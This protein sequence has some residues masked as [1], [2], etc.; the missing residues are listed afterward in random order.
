[1][2]SCAAVIL[3]YPVIAFASIIYGLIKL[4]KPGISRESRK[5]VLVRHILT[6]VGFIFA[7]A[8]PVYFLLTYLMDWPQGSFVFITAIFFAT[9][10]IYMT[11]FRI[12]EPYFVSVIK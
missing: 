3:L 4:N 7:E 8:Y 2:Y 9:E 6:I 11:L 12:A 1:M 5:L 10:G